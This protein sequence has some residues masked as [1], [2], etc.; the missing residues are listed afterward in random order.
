[1][2]VEKTS[3]L[4]YKESINPP[5]DEDSLSLKP[6]ESVKDDNEKLSDD[7]LQNLMNI[8]IDPDLSCTKITDLITKYEQALRTLEFE[9]SALKIVDILDALGV[10]RKLAK[11]IKTLTAKETPTN[12]T[13]G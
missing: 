1:L 3:F 12:Y 10:T 5:P 2:K 7:E 4:S 9:E 8:V 13:D 6:L 11:F